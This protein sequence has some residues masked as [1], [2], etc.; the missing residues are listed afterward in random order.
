MLSKPHLRFFT[1][2]C[3]NQ[4]VPKVVDHQER[5]AEIARALWRVIVR[6]GVEGASV[7]AVAAEAGWSAGAMR[8]YFAT[9]ESLLRFG[10]QMQL[11]RIPLRIQAI[12]S[13]QPPGRARAQDLLEQLLPLDEERMA[14]SLVWLAALGR[15]RIDP[16]LDD[17]RQQGWHG[18][19]Y[20][21]R[22]VVSD[23]LGRPWPTALGIPLGN[24][25]AEIEAAKL[26]ATV[27]GLTTLGAS[28]PDLMPPESTRK[29]LAAHL[30]DLTERLR[31]RRRD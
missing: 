18:E 26:H 7:R 3:H 11:E 20:L 21:C 8:H 28:F 6:S 2:S 5:Q 27:D 30:D 9:Q 25:R 14:E 1:R 17:L 13:S 22:A 16:D 15:A 4:S 31:S 12:A 29:L 24:R 10:I 23:L 19:R